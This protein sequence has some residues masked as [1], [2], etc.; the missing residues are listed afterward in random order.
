MSA[1]ITVSG[2]NNT[3]DAKLKRWFVFEV[4][5]ETNHLL[6][7]HQYMQAEG[8]PEVEVGCID[9]VEYD[10][11]APSI[12]LPQAKEARRRLRLRKRTRR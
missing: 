12:A 3:R 1:L 4:E 6:S 8:H 10:V 2:E 11:P 7:M 9:R 5:E